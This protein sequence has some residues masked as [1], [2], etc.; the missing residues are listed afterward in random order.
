MLP[1][2]RVFLAIDGKL[3]L[4]DTSD[5]LTPIDCDTDI[6]R[7]I[8]RPQ[9]R[10]VPFEDGEPIRLRCRN[11]VLAVDVESASARA[12]PLGDDRLLRRWGTFS[13]GSA[14]VIDNDRRALLRLHPDGDSRVVFP[15]P[16][17]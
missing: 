16:L 4:A 17:E 12:E 10:Q 3:Y 8:G 11:H 1:D 2:G 5:G 7:L 6:E 14:L 15:Q 13:D 9:A